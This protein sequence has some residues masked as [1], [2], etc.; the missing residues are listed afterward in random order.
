MESNDGVGIFVGWEMSIASKRG[1][2]H[3]NRTPDELVMAETRIQPS[4]CQG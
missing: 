1:K 3:Q 2:D 4:Q